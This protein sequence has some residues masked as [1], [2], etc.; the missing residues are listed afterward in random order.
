M[1]EFD[2]IM[3][4]IGIGIILLFFGL[5]SAKK[6]EK[7]I[8]CNKC[9]TKYNYEDDVEWNVIEENIGDKSSYAKVEITCTCP[10]CGEVKTFRANFTTAQIS[11]SG[12]VRRYSLDSS[13]KNYFK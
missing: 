3:F 11:S 5:L 1:G 7:R 12:C 4:F 10:K 2:L 8:H 6:H 9:N 13:I